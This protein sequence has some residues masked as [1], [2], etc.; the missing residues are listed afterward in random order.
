MTKVTVGIIAVS[1]ILA[2]LGQILLKAGMS[3]RAV[4]AAAQSG[5]AVQFVFA[6][7]TSWMVWVG[8]VVFGLSVLTWLVV[9]SKV[10]VSTAYPFAALG[11]VLTA[12]LGYLA[13]GESMG[14]GKVAG[15]ALICL[16]VVLVAKSA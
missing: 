7:A 13:F 15:I 16:G 3:A 6:V 9:L 10:E 8:L 12:T 5:G 1:V 11:M 14:A 4:Q 2:A